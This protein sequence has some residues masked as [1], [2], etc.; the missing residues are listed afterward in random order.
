VLS[1]AAADTAMFA[2]KYASMSVTVLLIAPAPANASNAQWCA[3]M[4]PG[5]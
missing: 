1:D 2:R 3:G 5:P 4:P